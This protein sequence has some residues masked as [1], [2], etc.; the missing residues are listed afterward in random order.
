MFFE[1]ISRSK[2]LGH[3]I[4]FFKLIFPAMVILALASP[5]VEVLEYREVTLEN[6]NLLVE[7]K[8][9][10]FI[11]LDVSKS[12]NNFGGT[13]TRFEMAKKLLLE[14]FKKLPEN[15]EVVLAKFSGEVKIVYSG[16]VGKCIEYLNEVKAGEKYTAIGDALSFAYSYSIASGNPVIVVLLTDGGQNYGSP[17]ED[18]AK[19]YEESKIPLIIVKIGSD[20]RSTVLNSL[21]NIPNCKI[22]S[23]NEFT[24]QVVEE[25]AEKY[26]RE[27]RYMA[28]KAKG[29]AVI[30]VVYR[31]Y[32]LT[33]VFEILSLISFIIGVVDGV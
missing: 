24:Y 32:T 13:V 30:P 27:A 8:V 15:D 9:V 14:Y 25:I 23:L 10:H 12:M 3:V 33:Y 28:L 26:S 6:V 7:K 22:L 21:R 5:Y 16:K 20:P 4:L 31:D 2:L 1:E 11:L 17:V 19:I 18:V 29:E